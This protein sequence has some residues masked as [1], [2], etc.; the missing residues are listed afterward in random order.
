MTYF[1]VL[2]TG[3]ELPNLFLFKN[4]HIVS[5]SRVKGMI[6]KMRKESH[7]VSLRLKSETEQNEIKICSI[8]SIII[9]IHYLKTA[10]TANLNLFIHK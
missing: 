9:C 5:L 6:G 2:D 1:C 10:K 3:V 8:I 4:K 7:E